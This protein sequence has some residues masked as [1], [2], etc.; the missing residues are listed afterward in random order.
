M[1]SIRELKQ[2]CQQARRETDDWY[3]LHVLRKISVRLTWLLLHTRINADWITLLFIIY[4]MLVCLVFLWGTKMAFFIG[5]LML[6]FWFVLDM[7]DGEIARY[8]NQMGAT[9]RFFD[10]MAHYIVH[11]CFFVAIGL[12]LFFRY[13]NFALFLC[14]IIAGYSV[15][16]VD[17]ISDVSCSVLYRRVRD[18]LLHP[19]KEVAF[20]RLSGEGLQKKEASILKRLFSLLH[21]VSIF[22]VIIYLMLVVSVVN[23]FV[24]VELFVPWIIFYAFSATLVWVGR[25]TFFIR[26]KKI[27]AE[28]TRMDQVLNSWG[29]EPNL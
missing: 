7:V 9:G 20:Q 28:Y 8:R 16:L 1:E 24:K 5:A 29:K 4:G 21:K 23:L 13:N 17:V 11:P 18:R 27:D 15:H 2:I 22:P 10:Y 12:G 14:A 3:M 25:M 26:K 6:Q 19:G